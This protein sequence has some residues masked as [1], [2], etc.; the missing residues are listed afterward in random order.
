MTPSK[1]GVIFAPSG[2]NPYSNRLR[3]GRA[4]CHEA[5]QIQAIAPAYIQY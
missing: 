5:R 4:W 3:I 2:T 1:R